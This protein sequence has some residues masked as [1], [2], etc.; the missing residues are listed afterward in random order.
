MKCKSFHSPHD[1]R[2]DPLKLLGIGILLTSIVFGATGWY[3]WS[4]RKADL[5]LV[6]HLIELQE[7]HG[8]ILHFDEVL[9]M[10]ARMAAAT[11]DPVWEERYREYE[12]KL[13][14][15]IEAVQFH[16]TPLDGGAVAE[17]EAANLEL[18]EMENRAF[19]LVRQGNHDAATHLLFSDEYEAQKALYAEGMVRLDEALVH[20]PETHA[21]DFRRHA[22][23]AVAMGVLAFLALLVIWTR[24]ALAVRSELARR[25]SAE[26]ALE[27]ER[28]SL[29]RKVERRTRDLRR[30]EE[31]FRSLV[32]NAND[33]I[34]ALSPEGVF[35]YISPNAREILG[36][37]PEE[38]VDRSIAD[39]AHPDDLAACEAFVHRVIST[40]EKQAGV[41]YRVR[42]GDGTWRWHTSNAAAL[43]DQH[44]NAVS[45]I[46]ISRDITERRLAQEELQMRSWF[47]QMLIDEI[48]SGIF[49]KSADGVYQGCNKTLCEWLG[50]SSDEIIG[51]TGHDLYPKELADVYQA[52]DNRLLQQP[53]REQY[54]YRLQHSDGS[55]RHA[56]FQKASYA[57]CGGKVDGLV[58][59]VTDITERKKAEEEREQLVHD[60]GERVKELRCL[61][62]LAELLWRDESLED[63]LTKAVT[64]L[65]PAWHY[66]ELTRAR[67]RF[68]GREYVSEP[69]ED[70]EWRQTSDITVGSGV[71]GTVEVYYLE[72]RRELDEGPF[73]KE[74]RFLLDNVARAIG[75]RIDRKQADERLAATAYHLTE[76][77]H[78]QDDLLGPGEVSEKL[79]KITDGAVRIFGADFCRIWITKPGDLCESGCLHNQPEQ[80]RHRCVDRDRCLH[81]KA[82][83]GRYTHLDGPV[84][85]RVPFGCYKI[86]TLAAGEDH[87]LLTN[88]V[89]SDPR[90]HNHE[91]ASE[92]GL[93]S[94][95]GYP[96]RPPGGETLGV[97]ALFSK[98]VITADDD[99]LLGSL[100]HTATLVIQGANA[101]EEHR[102]LQA[103]LAQ[104]QRLES[105]GQLASGIAHEIN[106]PAQFVSD[107]TRFLQKAFPK[108]QQIMTVHGKLLEAIRTGP[109]ASELL[110]EAEEITR[111][112]KIDFLLEQVPEA[113]ADS[114]EGLE[115]V[116][117]IVR[118][119]KDFSHPGQ[120][121]MCAAD[122]NHAIK[123]TITVAR[124]EWKYVADM[125]MDL[126]P[127]LPPVPCSL[128]DFNQVILNLV[129]NAAHA[130]AD[131]VGDGGDGK[132]TITVSTRNDG[133]HVEV[134][135]HDTGTGIPQE[136]RHRIFEHFFTTK[137]VGKGTGQGL[138]I[139]RSVIVDKHG[140]QI[141]FETETGK[142][143]TFIIRLPVEAQSKP[144]VEL[145]DDQAACVIR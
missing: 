67:I 95:A 99:A 39:Y 86:G 42:C 46:G 101:H 122:L 59:V 28:R 14:A 15:A 21:A 117:N 4:A 105:V 23:L 139:A 65:P 114:L 130:I 82:S 19:D 71:L 115:R 64:L 76:F 92:L 27:Q 113:I 62:A 73:L 66:P 50:R 7:L 79:N 20:H 131:V 98:R 52:A 55:E 54:E 83:S 126:D 25:R 124:N 63:M 120:Q 108:L 77:N 107:N 8:R 72:Q 119:M 56:L 100:A 53:A 133:D 6:T 116:T 104:S 61:H 94:F 143:T 127:S 38:M 134:R 36:H 88:E 44:G 128:G 22:L 97:M 16:H 89:A 3:V 24:V 41:E 35:T 40:G 5:S 18:V 112:A 109:V 91:W 140:G 12:P 118:A 84:H 102:L 78:L 34:Y 33:V 123:S 58:G 90:I 43:K 142:G 137:Q 70:T 103:Q 32:E 26:E 29:E 145:R 144:A 9:T 111:K 93:A 48:P 96:L 57:G 75:Q 51:H 47:L 30:S 2:R 60:L 10:S 121:E 138:A 141:A 81:L 11:G 13:A 129:V 68:E 110:A 69:F 49:W 87:R 74:E 1:D 125:E 106:T 136:N 17:T 85:R 37:A 135:V 132:G 45:Y 31:R 80:D